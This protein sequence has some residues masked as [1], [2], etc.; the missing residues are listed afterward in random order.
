MVEAPAE[1]HVGLPRVTGKEGL[2]FCGGQRGP[3]E[4]D[5]RKEEA[6][7]EAERVTCTKADRCR[8][9][10]DQRTPQRRSV[11]VGHE[12]LVA[13]FAGVSRALDV[14]ADAEGSAVEGRPAEASDVRALAEH[15][16]EHVLGLWALKRQNRRIIGQVLERHGAVLGKVLA[17]P[18]VHDRDH[19]GIGY[20]QDFVVRGDGED[21]VVDD[22][23]VVVHE[24]GVGAAARRHGCHALGREGLEPTTHV[25]ALESKQAH[26]RHVKQSC[27]GP[28]GH[29]FS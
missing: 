28:G 7:L 16:G 17:E 3:Q 20:A 9:G 25:C 13:G 15:R 10:L 18:L 27:S 21:H 19:R 29:V 12:D 1:G 22:V 5:A 6:L 4:V 23:A 24:V 11:A 26:V 2:G 8:S 14:A